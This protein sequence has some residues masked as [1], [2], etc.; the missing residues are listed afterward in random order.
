MFV[1]VLLSVVSFV[2]FLG[3]AP[4]AWSAV[5]VD[6]PWL[7]RV[8]ARM[9]NSNGL[10]ISSECHWDVVQAAPSLSATYA[11]ER[12]FGGPITGSLSGTIDA[13][14]GAFSLSGTSM[15]SAGTMSLTGT[16]A[17][18]SLSFAG[19]HVCGLFTGTFTASLCGN[20]A[21]DAGEVCDEGVDLLD[22][23]CCSTTCQLK[24]G[25]T[26]CGAGD[27]D[28]N[29]CTDF[30]CDGASGACP[31]TNSPVPAGRVCGEPSGCS[32][33]ACDGAGSCSSSNTLPD[34]HFCVGQCF[35]GRGT[36][37]AGACSAPQYPAG[38]VC[39]ADANPCTLD[40]CNA[41]GVCTTGGCSACCDSSG[42]GC[43][44]A[45]ETGCEAPVVGK[46]TITMT[47]GRGKLTWRWSKGD[48][49]DFGTPEVDGAAI[50][51]YNGITPELMTVAQANGGTCG[52]PP[53]WKAAGKSTRYKG[54][55]P[56]PLRS[57]AVR[58]G[59]AGKASIAVQASGLSYSHWGA[60]FQN[61][62]IATP[63]RVQLKTGG[64]CWESTFFAFRKNED[65]VFKAIGGSPSGAFVDP[66]AA[67]F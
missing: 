27:G 6:G 55:K 22:R 34:G 31:V 36:C 23:D 53:C 17:G 1:R 30:V 57:V 64:R 63:V 10:V 21:L 59:A 25:G 29:A 39:H 24:T 47:R 46:S 4:T 52:S 19:T 56:D 45:Y 26:I 43:E 54:G 32:I 66:V 8:E 11:C 37:Q 38:T 51:V 15:C 33:A 42:G 9:G 5:D 65:Y 3:A 20:D 60:H 28:D 13:D 18:D 61:D 67:G 41:S 2:S 7:V 62:P 48:E 16:V 58:D 49:A 50:C 14:S 40:S 35:K 12:T 44:E